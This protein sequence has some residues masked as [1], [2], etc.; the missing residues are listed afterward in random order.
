MIAIYRE[1]T[2][3][4]KSTKTHLLIRQ[5]YSNRTHLNQN[6]AK[7]NILLTFS[8]GKIQDK[9]IFNR[10][11]LSNG[12]N[13]KPAQDLNLQGFGRLSENNLLEK[14]ENLETQH[15]QQIKDFYKK[16]KTKYKEEIHQKWV[17][18]GSKSEQ[19]PKKIYTE[20]QGKQNETHK[21]FLIAFGGAEI[22][23]NDKITLESIDNIEFYNKCVKAVKKQLNEIGLTEKN[24][25]SV[26][27][28]RDEKTPHLHVRYTNFDFENC[29]SLNITQKQQ[30]TNKTHIQFR[31]NLLSELQKTINQS[32]GFEFE[33]KPRD[34]TIKHKTKREWLIE[35]NIELQ[36]QHKQK[37]N[38]SRFLDNAISSKKEQLQ[39]DYLTFNF[40]NLA[41][42]Y[43]FK[44]AKKKLE[45]I[46]EI[47]LKPVMTG[48]EQQNLVD[49][50]LQFVRLNLGNRAQ[51]YEE[52]KSSYLAI[53][54]DA[55]NFV[56][57][58]LVKTINKQVTR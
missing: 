33:P 40:K 3:R 56:Q 26:I 41:Q 29:Q 2:S 36:A 8:N 7:D 22:V 34:P 45:E 15:Y 37:I 52:E 19:K 30:T 46:Q 47:G 16:T 32:L 27:F 38:Q 57:P 43:N 21:E 5:D 49:L 28:H 20:Y 14:Y 6:F 24:L 11:E 1:A 35:Q 58:T 55:K 17:E 53:K 39:D 51:E 18:N 4:T 42:K 10:T 12:N 9:I 13:I 23:N 25:V 48:Q 50:F 31:K 54:N 44:E